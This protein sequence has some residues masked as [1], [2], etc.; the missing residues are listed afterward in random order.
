M[1]DWD[2]RDLRAL[3]RSFRRARPFPHVIL[4]GLLSPL[5]HARVM[6]DFRW[7]PHRLLE[8]EIYRQMRAG[9]P[10]QR[11]V[12]RAFRDHLVSMLGCS[13]VAQICGQPLSRGDGAGYVYLEG[14]YLLPHA[15]WRP[16]EGRALAYAYYISPPEAGGELELFDC[17][18]ERGEIV[19]TRPARRIAPRANR[20][21]LFEVS[22][23]ALHQVREVTRGA[24]MSI[25]G[26][27]YP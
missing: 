9:D 12:V 5:D 4:D 17:T 22:Q 3:A 11:P 19:R 1:I 26:W 24:R 20:L 10:P 6:D 13:K 21:V 18:L 14:H 15:D 25:A 16:G 27:Y 2:S 7:E 8:D 23:R